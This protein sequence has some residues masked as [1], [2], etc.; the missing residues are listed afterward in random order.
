MTRAVDTDR[1]EGIFGIWKLLCRFFILFI[2]SEGFPSL[3]G[4]ELNIKQRQV[5]DK[6]VNNIEFM[7]LRIAYVLSS[8]SFI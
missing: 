2:V 6:Q 5:S 4:L 8:T 3:G 7:K 1:W